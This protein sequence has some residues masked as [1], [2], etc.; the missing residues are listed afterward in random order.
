MSNSLL[1]VIVGIVALLVIIAVV[2]YA[3]SRR[4]RAPFEVRPVPENY[5]AQYQDRIDELERMFVNQPREA[6]AAA[7]LLVDDLL[8]RM[9]YP[10]RMNEQERLRD[11]KYQHRQHMDRYRTGVGLK[12]TASTEQLRRALRN[13]LEMTREMLSEHGQRQG[14]TAEGS[15]RL[16][17]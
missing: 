17:G 15:R 16:A 2:V 1:W 5:V 12:D 4:R 3:M 14:E 10:V 8:T 6:V 7:K 11:L 9:G 13:Y